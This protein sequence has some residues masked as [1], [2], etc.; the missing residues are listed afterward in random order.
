MPLALRADPAPAKKTRAGYAH[1]LV[2]GCP[3][4]STYRRKVR[5]IKGWRAE[6]AVRT[7]PDLPPLDDPAAMVEWWQR[8]KVQTVPTDLLASRSDYLSRLPA[9]IPAASLAGAAPADPRAPAAPRAEPPANPRAEITDFDGVEALDLPTAIIRQQRV[10][11]VLQRDYERA[12]CSPATDES[13]LTLRAGRVDKCLERLH[14]LQKTLTAEQI[15]NG[16]LIPR[17][18]LRDELAPLLDTLAASLVSELSDRFGTERARATGFVDLWFRHLRDSR[19]FTEALPPP[20]ASP[21]LA[22]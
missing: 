20:A 18:A 14:Q 6:G 5:V 7:P 21:A 1:S 2:S 13:T 15:K 17:H 19:L 3:Y 10:L 9:A 16:D 4:E 12:L 8:V 22:A 11:S